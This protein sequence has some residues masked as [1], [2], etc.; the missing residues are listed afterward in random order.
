MNFP[1]FNTIVSTPGVPG[2]EQPVRELLTNELNGFAN[3]L[4]TDKMGN[5]IASK[6]NGEVSVMLAAHMD[7]IGLITTYVDDQGFIRFHTLG[8]F[9]LRTL[10]TQ[11]VTVLG[12]EHLPGVIGGKPSHVLTQEEKKKAPVM[13]DLFIDVGLPAEKVRELVPVGTPVTRNRSCIEMG[14]LVTGK[15]L[16]NRISVYTL[17]E[18][19]KK[20]TV[21]DNIT[22]N[23]VF[24]VQE[25]VGLRGVRVAAE[26]L[27]P[28][29]GI[30]MDTTIANDIPGVSSQKKIS[31]VGK[32]PAVKIMDGSVI[33]SPELVE[34]MESVASENNIPVQREILTSGGTDTPAMQYLTGVGAYVSC[35]SV[36]TRYIH[37]TVESASI[38]DIDQSISLT[39]A[40]VSSLENFIKTVS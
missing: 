3:E 33:S 10:F 21:P 35:I 18:A 15:S 22:L 29:I 24:T 16:D 4:K 40:L 8:G 14:E 9:D 11:R 32:G 28:K 17:L 7:E 34:H 37:S 12:K 30:A 25:E 23:A 38:N 6:G 36:P 31:E 5:L 20:C 2:F 26:A 39:V 13:D 1:L 27:K 19:F